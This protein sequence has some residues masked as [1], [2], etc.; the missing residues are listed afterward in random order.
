MIGAIFC[1]IGMTKKRQRKTVKKILQK[2][3]IYDTLY[4]KLVAFLERDKSLMLEPPKRIGR[5]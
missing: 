2:V 4:K 1:K 5:T 3:R